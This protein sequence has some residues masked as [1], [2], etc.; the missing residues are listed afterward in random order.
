[1]VE[2]AAD[3]GDLDAL[4]LLGTLYQEGRGIRQSITNNAVRCFQK[5]A[6]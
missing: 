6:K 3:Q 2:K 4:N 5:A 1:M